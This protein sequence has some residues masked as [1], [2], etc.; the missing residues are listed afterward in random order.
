MAMKK[1]PD[2][3]IVVILL[4]SAST[5]RTAKTIAQVTQEDHI[6]LELHQVL[7]QEPGFCVLKTQ[8]VVAEFPTLCEWDANLNRGALQPRSHPG[9]TV[10]RG[11]VLDRF[12][13]AAVR[14]CAESLILRHNAIAHVFYLEAR[15]RPPKEK[16][17]CSNTAWSLMTFHFGP[18]MLDLPTSGSQEKDMIP[19][20]WVFA[21]TFCLRQ[22]TRTRT[23]HNTKTS[24]GR[25]TT[26]LTVATETIPLHP[27]V[28]RRT[29]RS[30][31]RLNTQPAHLD[32][33][34]TQQHLSLSLSLCTPSDIDFELAQRISSS[35][36]RDSAGAIL[37]C[38]RLVASRDVPPPLGPHDG[39][40]AW[41]D[42]DLDAWSTDL[43][44]P[45]EMIEDESVT[46]T[47][48]T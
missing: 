36:H 29:R 34:P 25:F 23:L 45:A 11:Q 27:S 38:V 33:P 12:C 46:T 13:D 30:L 44:S 41:D 40:P 43:G 24:N 7:E 14:P 48:T 17:D 21:V 2:E 4:P 6:S 31:G 8:R 10:P 47:T 28:L 32:I 15:S 37:R 26:Q 19:E 22:A 16:E 35:L 9:R 1:Q 18:V 20:V 39:W 42:P 5:V 3:E